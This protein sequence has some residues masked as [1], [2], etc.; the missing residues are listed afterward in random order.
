MDEIGKAVGMM[1]ANW[2][3]EIT[4]S[5]MRLFREVLEDVDD[6]DMMVAVM[7][8]IKSGRDFMPT[9]GQIRERAREVK[10]ERL[11]YQAQEELEKKRQSRK[12]KTRDQDQITKE[13]EDF[14]ALRREHK[15]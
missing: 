15:I 2:S 12:P 14:R 13:Q 10:N 4:P 11:K 3:K 5:M 9:A 8:A 7:G 1:T 6:A